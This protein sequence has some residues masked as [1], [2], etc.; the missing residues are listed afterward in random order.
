MSRFY[1][2]HRAMHQQAFMPIFCSDAFDSKAQVE[3]C[4][5]AGCTVIEYTLRKSDAR[6]MI[7]W[8][9]RKSGGLLKAIW[10]FPRRN[11]RGLG[12]GS[13]P[14]TMPLAG[15]GWPRCH[16]ITRSEALRD[17]KGPDVS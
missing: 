12:P 8:I 10:R 17:G 15:N 1:H 6:E 7:P 16:T 2:T 9:R 11:A 13:P 5:A 14:P 3:A 4:V